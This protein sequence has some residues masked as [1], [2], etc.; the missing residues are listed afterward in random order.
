MMRLSA[1][2]SRLMLETLEMTASR[3]TPPLPAQSAKLGRQPTK[4]RT[5]LVTLAGICLYLLTCVAI[6]A[7]SHS[8]RL[9]PG[10]A[11][12]AVFR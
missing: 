7:F 5:G 12:A 3:E 6:G 9:F 1:I 2:C 8:V 4:R 10:Q 11:Q